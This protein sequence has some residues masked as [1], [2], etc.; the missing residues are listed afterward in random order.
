MVKPL[1]MLFLII[2]FFSDTITGNSQSP[3][4][5]IRNSPIGVGETAPDFT[6]EDQNLN[7]ITLSDAR[8]QSPVVL[9]FY[10]GYW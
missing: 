7:K 3:A 8:G 10:R 6:L 5:S 9:A 4:A 2:V 1:T